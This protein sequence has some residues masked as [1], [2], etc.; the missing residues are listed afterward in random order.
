MKV[1]FLGG[2]KRYLTIVSELSKTNEI[3]L[4]GYNSVN[5]IGNKVSENLIDFSKYNIIILP[6]SGINKN[7]IV[8][9]LD[10]D[11]KISK[12][13]LKNISE[14]C[15]IFTGLI[16]K[17][18]QEINSINIISFLKDKKIKDFNNEITVEGIIEDIKERKKQKI[19][20]LGYGNIGQKIY[21]IL[22][23]E[24]IDI[25]VG[26]IEKS[27]MKSV[28]KW[29][30][31]NDTI[32]FIRQVKSS[33][34]IINTVPENILKETIAKNILESTYILD[35][36]SYPHGVDKKLVDKYNLNYKLY[37][38]I[39]GKY[40]PEKSGNILIR[41]IKEIIESQI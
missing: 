5:T 25:V 22:K 18:I 15:M 29:F 39:P 11:I 23:K 34:I 10:G 38:G 14:N 31:T 27:K 21:Y 17:P 6:M 30:D 19:C 8:K 7:M 9:S 20:L 3:D 35:V 2:D 37:L 40:K 33:D 26:E 41:K 36:A 1:L 13:K 12:E 4:V 16:T 32:E 24:N 28:Q